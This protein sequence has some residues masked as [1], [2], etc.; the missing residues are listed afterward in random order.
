MP[1]A[2]KFKRERG[3]SG[4]S[5]GWSY[6]KQLEFLAPNRDGINL[7]SH[8]G[9]SHDSALGALKVDGSAVGQVIAHGLQIAQAFESNQ[10]QFG[11]AQRP[12][13]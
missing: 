2:F 13:L 8:F 9:E 7:Q 4:G 1:F 5:L 3:Q 10:I 12:P 6:S 11:G